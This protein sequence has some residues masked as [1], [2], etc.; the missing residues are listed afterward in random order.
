MKLE[1]F[2]WNFTEKSE[3]NRDLKWDKNY[4]VLFY[5]L[6]WYKIFLSF[7][8]KQNKINIIIIFSFFSLYIMW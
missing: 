3:M 2:S 6:N 7:Q 1:Y 8:T 4:F 5:F